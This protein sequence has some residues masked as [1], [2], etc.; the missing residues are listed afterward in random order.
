MLAAS[1]Q[2]SFST[3]DRRFTSN[4]FVLHSIFLGTLKSPSLLRFSLLALN[5][6]DFFNT[7]QASMH[8]HFL[9]Q[10]SW[11]AYQ[12][13]FAERVYPDFL[14]VFALTAIADPLCFLQKRSCILLFHDQNL[15]SSVQ[16][17]LD[18]PF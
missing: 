6:L 4:A 7:P 17:C 13:L 9:A 2:S 1:H 18:A 11:R 10:L 15:L 8:S 12:L 3:S 14:S 16:S 5:F